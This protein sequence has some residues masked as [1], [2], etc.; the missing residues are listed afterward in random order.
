MQLVITIRSGQFTAMPYHIFL[1][2]QPY[3]VYI[4]TLQFSEII[5]HSK[6][7]IGFPAAKIQNRDFSVFRKLRKDIPDKLQ[8]R[9][10]CL[11]LSYLEATIF[12]SFVITP[13][14]TRNGAA[15]PSLRMYCFT[16]L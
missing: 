8:K 6:S 9:L 10:I 7:K 12:P 4:K 11:N 1:K 13:R 14:S 16:R 15:V 3:D 5:R 2:I